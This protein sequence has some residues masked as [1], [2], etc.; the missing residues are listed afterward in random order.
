MST[1]LVNTSTTVPFSFEGQPVRKINRNGA[2]WFVL[3]DVCRVL[4]IG[5][6]RDAASRLDNDEKDTVGNTDSIRGC[7][8]NVDARPQSITIV[9]E[10]GLYSLVLTSRKPAAKRFKKWVTSE[11]IPSI[12]K[13]GG[14]GKTEIYKALHDPLTLRMLLAE[15]NEK[16]L[17]LEGTIEDMQAD[18]DAHERLCKADGSL[19]ITVAAKTFAARGYGHHA[20]AQ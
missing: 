11:V 12:R 6:S 5:N 14:Y 20:H 17:A 10:S 18:V 13:T 19:N 8:A 7:G 15:T 2:P 16:V 3:A 4:E 1:D 9:N